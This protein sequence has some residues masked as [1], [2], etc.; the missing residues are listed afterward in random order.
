MLNVC[1]SECTYGAMR[2]GL[3]EKSSYGYYELC[4]GPIQPEIL[5]KDRKD[6]R[7]VKK[8]LKTAKREK[9]IRVW[10]ANNATDK[11]GLYHLVNA[12][13]DVDCK[14]FVVEMPGDLGFRPSD[15]EKFWTE[16]EPEDFLACLH[17]ARE[18]NID[19]R[20][21]ISKKWQQLVIENTN[22]RIIQDGEIVSVS[23]DYLDNIILSNAPDT[24][25]FLARK[26]VGETIGRSARYFGIGFV[27]WRIEK[28]IENGIFSVVQEAEDLEDLEHWNMMILRKD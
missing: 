4:Y 20:N 13:Q 1:F 7:R 23:D 11:C 24:T 2:Y 26:L 17:L 3:N 18:L 12:L 22:L 5:D 27:E 28:M 14:I 8:I 16:V 9:E 25:E 6:K 15:W 21:V 10:Y 19:E